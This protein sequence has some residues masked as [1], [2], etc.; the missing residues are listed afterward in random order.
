MF[1]FNVNKAYQNFFLAF[2]AFKVKQKYIYNNYSFLFIFLPFFECIAK[3]AI[4]RDYTV[5]VFFII[6]HILM[7]TEEWLSTNVCCVLDDLRYYN[8]DL[9]DTYIFVTYL[10]SEGFGGHVSMYVPMW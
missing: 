1:V 2:S 4:I 7:Y 6:L 8:N 10:Y 9:N 3:C 5:Y